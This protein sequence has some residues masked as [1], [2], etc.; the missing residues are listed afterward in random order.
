MN[1]AM[2]RFHIFSICALVSFVSQILFAGTL[3][4]QEVESHSAY[5][6]GTDWANHLDYD[7]LL[8]AT[9][10]NNPD[11]YERMVEKAKGV[12]RAQL[13]GGESFFVVSQAG[14]GFQV[15]TASMIHGGA[16][17]V[18]WLADD[19]LGSIG[20]ETIDALVTGLEQRVKEGP[21]TRDPNKG[22][23]E[24][25][26]DI[27]G[28]PVKDRWSDGEVKLHILL[29]D[30]ESPIDGG[31]IEGYFSSFDQTTYYGSNERNLLYVDLKKLVQ[32][33]TSTVDEILGTIAHEF[34]HLIN[35]S[36]Y[37]GPGNKTHWIYNE[38]LSEVAS[39]RNGYRDRDAGEYLKS[40]NR[41]S[42]F[43]APTGSGSADTILRGYERSMLWIHYLSERFGDE[44]LYHLVP[45]T[46]SNLEPVRSAMQ[47]TG[48][49]SDVES[50]MGQFW[51]ANYVQGTST[52][53]GES[54]FK[55]TYPVSA[56]S[57][58]T[59]NKGG[60]PEE[61]EE[62]AVDVLGHAAY[63]PRYVSTNP[64]AL[65]VKVRFIPNDSPYKVHAVLFRPDNSI[66]V[67]PVDIGEEQIFGNY[68]NAIFAVA[69]VSGS[70]QT[71]RWVAEVAEIGNISGVSDYATATGVLAFTDIAPNPVRDEARFTFRTAGSGT[72]RLDLID[73]RGGIVRRIPD[74]GPDG[75]G[76]R[77][78]TLDLSDLP[79]GVYMAR[80]QDES[81]AIAARQVVV[82]K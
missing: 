25:D 51:A 70:M 38:G 67:R 37:K 61:P 14:Q 76:A 36:R 56:R 18:I 53:Q 10:R 34:Q 81:G 33:G 1:N 50:V 54:Q 72:V 13:A 28:E 62:F 2:K 21:T 20:Q 58:T 49:G 59:V 79:A 42:Y 39:I 16:D 46:G 75:A 78:L 19:Y 68:T 43:D 31:S 80:L 9:R 7:S 64:S 71:I 60:A 45:A 5:T 27:F 35:Y 11:V 55:Y 65:G 30:I 41:F 32:G 26:I 23:I 48:N 47:Q 73:V 15:M 82:V 57:S 44:F 8:E 29:L 3:A 69:N 74:V 24:N 4:A 6:C 40:P 12:D 66:E 63:F 22:V 52:F 17:A 77:S